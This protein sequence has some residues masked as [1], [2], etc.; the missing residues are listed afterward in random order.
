[1]K[2]VSFLKSFFLFFL[3]LSIPFVSRGE[4]DVSQLIFKAREMRL[5][6]DPYWLSLNHYHKGILGGMKSRIDEK[7]F[8]FSKQGK[9]NP[10]KEMEAFILK[11][12]S[13]EVDDAC[14]HIARYTWLYQKLGANEMG[15][16]PPQCGPLENV[17]P[18]SAR[19]V[20]PTYY[21]NNPASMFGHTLVTIRSEN[22]SPM[23]DRAVNY[24]ASTGETSGLLFAVKGLFGAY[25]GYFTVLPYYKKIQEYGE[26]EQRDIWE[27]TLDFSP[28]EL[29]AMV[30][31]IREMEEVYSR[32]YFLDENCSFN[33][34]YLMEAA[35]PGVSITE[36]FPL[37]VL[38]VDTLR[39]LDEEGLI[40]E[41][42]YRPSR[43]SIIR[44]RLSLLPSDGKDLAAMILDRKEEP[45]KAEELDTI[46]AIR[47]LDTV[48][49]LIRYRFA[50][51]D[52]AH[53]EYRDLLTRTL[54]VRSRFGQDDTM[55]PVPAPR[56]PE[57][58]HASSRF[59]FGAKAV[60]GELAGTFSFRPALTDLTDPDYPEKDGIRIV[61]GETRLRVGP[62]GE[63][64]QLE[65]L[66]FIDITSLSPRDRFFKP[67][68]WSLGFSLEGVS[69]EDRGR[70]FKSY[71]GSGY[72]WAPDNLGLFSMQAQPRF[73]A[74]SGL[75]DGYSLGAMLR[76]SWI[77]RLGDGVKGEVFGEYGGFGLGHTGPASALGA[78]LT[79]RLSRNLHLGLSCAHEDMWG[80]SEFEPLLE[81]RWFH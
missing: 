65:K 4:Q 34:M 63:G 68:S 76:G 12:F 24:A 14:P 40:V 77:F 25:P 7:D 73:Y 6:E 55:P 80:N 27:Y 13:G 72:T 66:D 48:I 71:F 10:E 19:L 46:E 2:F 21:M 59:A 47:V 8:F 58:V 56:P 57:T 75:E 60:D 81:F 69:G 20:F 39:I 51:R 29:D 3:F 50:S 26:M 42:V 23:L 79:T 9:R 1:M 54:K 49:D 36:G 74:G 43:A 61:F 33:L 62:K 52:M 16:P 15:F 67:L 41:R 44:H 37:W 64:V 70:L 32:Y 17:A 5:A 78:E 45:E 38:P 31:H 22:T 35:R 30:R 11:L 18:T 53:D 28:E